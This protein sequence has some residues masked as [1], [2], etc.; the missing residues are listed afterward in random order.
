MGVRRETL[1]DWKNKYPNIANALK[2][3][4]QQANFIIENELF[5]KAIGGNTTAMI[6]WLKNN[7][8]NKYN[9]SQLSIEEREMTSARKR[10]LL[11]E[12]KLI[13]H[14]VEAI[15]N[16]DSVD[17]TT[18]IVDDIKEID[19]ATNSKDKSAD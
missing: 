13:E 19:N 4:K 8:R 18:F 11:A 16:P 9:D 12:T 14:Q 15:N 17:N 5:R 7:W 6:F 10:K 3:G 1:Y 2:V